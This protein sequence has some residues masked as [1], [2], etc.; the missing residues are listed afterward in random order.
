MIHTRILKVL[1]PFRKIGLLIF[2]IINYGVAIS[3]E[4][5]EKVY[6][7]YEVTSIPV[8]EE[9]KD[10]PLDKDCFQITLQLHINKLLSYPETAL[11]NNLEGMVYTQFV[12]N[13]NGVVENIKARSKHTILMDEAIRVLNNFPKLQPASINGENIS[14]IYSHPIVFKIK[15]E[16]EI[17]TEP[18]AFRDA[19]I[20]PSHPNCDKS[21]DQYECFQKEVEKSIFSSINFK[22]IQNSIGGKKEA[23]F[24]FNYYFK[25]DTD[26]S[27]ADAVVI[28]SNS[29]LKDEVLKYLNSGNLKLTAARNENNE[30]IATFITSNIG[31]KRRQLRGI[32]YKTETKTTRRV[33]N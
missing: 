27:I 10:T 22:K 24:S 31:P 9:C 8:F 7:F 12:I 18:I 14:V 3:Q 32:G 4:S 16:V 1:L 33:R 11:E 17:E 2:L 25:I 20:P 26:G 30:P 19:A 28:S 29:T 5:V 21:K 15:R 13:K 23:L 6:K